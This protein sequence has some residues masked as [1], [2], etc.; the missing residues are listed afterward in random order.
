MLVFSRNS[1]WP[2]VMLKG[3]CSSCSLSCFGWWNWILSGWLAESYSFT[4]I[5][6]SFQ[7]PAS[8]LEKINFLKHY[9]LSSFFLDLFRYQRSTTAIS[10]GMIQLLLCSPVFC[11]FDFHGTCV[12]FVVFFLLTNLNVPSKPVTS[13]TYLLCPP[14]SNSSVQDDEVWGVHW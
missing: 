4:I 9:T 2:Y 11:C 7:N 5:C 10:M 13:C 6:V 1:C 3:N 12:G 14:C 8:L